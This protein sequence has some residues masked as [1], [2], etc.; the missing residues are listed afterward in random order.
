MEQEIIGLS[1]CIENIVYIYYI[2]SHV[3]IL[4]LF[5]VF[6]IQPLSEIVFL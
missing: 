2:I 3:K 4:I 1:N 6:V 5:A